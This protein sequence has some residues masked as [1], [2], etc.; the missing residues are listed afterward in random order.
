M[1]RPV[2]AAAVLGVTILQGTS[3]NTAAPAREPATG[4]APLLYISIQGLS[5]R[6]GSHGEASASWPL[7]VGETAQVRVRAGSPEVPSLCGVGSGSAEILSGASIGWLLEGDLV[8][9]DATGVRAR[10]RWK[11]SILQ[12]GLAH[13]GDFEREYEVRLEEGARMTLDLVRPEPGTADDCDGVVVQTWMDFS[14]PLEL[15]SQLLDFDIW[16]VHREPDGRERVDRASGR[17]LHGQDLRYQFRTLRYDTRGIARE[18]GDVEL[19][20]GGRVKARI[21][22]GGR[23]DLAVSA[24]RTVTHGSLGSGEHG[25]KQAAV[26]DGETVEIELPPHHSN[27]YTLPQRSAVRVTVRR[28]G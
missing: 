8:E 2:I 1:R 18:D 16:L 5:S 10:L 13:V 14:D 12:P 20:L 7:K 24:G 15:T 27:R 17:T 4:A 9:T 11:R 21:Q 19:K 25:T 3:A 26:R 23:I 6:G 22:P 28:V